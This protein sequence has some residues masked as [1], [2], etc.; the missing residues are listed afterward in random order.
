MSESSLVGKSVL[1]Y[2]VT[3]IL[4]AGNFGTVYKAVKK[5]PSGEYVRAL[6]HIIIPS[7]KQ[8]ESIFNSMG[9]DLSKVDDYFSEMLKNIV[10]EIQILNNLSEKGVRNIVRYYENDITSTETPKRYSIFILMEH[11]TP[12]SDYIAKTEFS[13]KDVIK[14]GLDVLSALDSCHNN[15]VIHRDIKDDN[16]FVS[17]NGEFKIGD[18]GVSKVLKDSSK[19]ESIKGTPNFLAPEVY[20][21]KESYTKSVDLYSLGI[22]LYRLLNYNRN[23]FLPR[24]P[25]AYDF[26]DEEKAFDERMKESVPALPSLGG[27]L[28]GNIIIKAISGRND[29][30][31]VAKEFYDVLEMAARN[32][33]HDIL[34]AKIRASGS[35]S[36]RT[37]SEDEKEA[38]AISNETIKEKISVDKLNTTVESEAPPISNLFDTVGAKYVPQ[39]S[40]IK[41]S[42]P[43]SSNSTTS[44]NAERDIQIPPPDRYDSE[45]TKFKDNIMMNKLKVK[46]LLTVLIIIVVYNV[47]AFA[48]PFNRFGSFWSGYCFIML[49]LIL[50]AT[51]GLYSLDKQGLKSKFYGVP[52]MY[53][54]WRYLIIQLIVGF[55]QMFL[56]FIPFQYG[57]VINVILLG[58][59]LIGLI[60]TDFGKEK[61][62]PIDGKVKEKAFYIK[63]LQGEVSDLADRASSE[64]VKKVL[65]GLAETIRYSDPM[66]SPQLATIENKIEGKVYILSDLVGQADDVAVDLLCAELQQLLAERNRKCRILK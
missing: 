59:C 19:A 35:T 58:I 63:S 12:L 60:A 66:S 30:Y 55:V 4:G 18:F 51:V 50:T 41:T 53:L 33:S 34:S 61:I 28:I 6:K 38:P 15:G 13:V 8:Y 57:I 56:D 48:I 20:L 46:S 65:K 21:G 26:K 10:T 64:S 9:G 42:I 62:E 3:E 37:I 27:E 14:L 22:V 16:I 24:F 11:L 29:R 39:A 25:E 49:A 43:S 47:V 45:L 40:K 7:E 36:Y 32:T 5:N 31:S 52:L 44:T 17:E 1:G 54:T 2:T 23:P